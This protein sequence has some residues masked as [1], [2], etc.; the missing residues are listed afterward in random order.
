MQTKVSQGMGMGA[1]LT[2]GSSCFKD[3]PG[4]F[5]LLVLRDAVLMDIECCLEAI[6]VLDRVPGWGGHGIK[7]SSFPLAGFG[8]CHTKRTNLVILTSFFRF[9]FL[10]F[11]SL[12]CMSWSCRF[13]VYS[14]KGPGP[15]LAP[16]P[17]IPP[18]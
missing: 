16:S 9:V 13:K 8:L 12:P 11:P 1:I 3:F 15:V 18:A 6:P 7:V 2:T 17:T 14:P 10:S 5:S 4:V